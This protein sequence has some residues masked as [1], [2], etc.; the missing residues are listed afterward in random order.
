M[1]KP[2]DEQQPQIL[3]LHNHG[4]PA[5]P[6][7]VISDQYLRY[8]TGSDWSEPQDLSEAYLYADSTAGLDD[9]HML[10][11]KRYGKKRLRRFLA[12]LCIELYCDSEVS[13]EDLKEWFGRVSKLI[14]DTPTHGNGPVAGSYG[15]C[16]IDFE[17]MKEMKQP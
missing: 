6:R 1:T 4:S 15:S 16:L 8:W 14:M 9:M 7:F 17:E 10:M 11:V 13:I 2:A 5:F 3:S 12:P